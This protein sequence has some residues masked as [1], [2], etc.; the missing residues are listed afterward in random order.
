MYSLYF[1]TNVDYLILSNSWFGYQTLLHAQ[2]DFRE[3]AKKQKL[4][5]DYALVKSRWVVKESATSMLNVL[6]EFK[7]LK[8][9]WISSDMRMYYA[10]SKS[11]V[12]G[13]KI[14]YLGLLYE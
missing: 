14:S 4:V 11:D 6:R 13:S 7:G 3:V 8:E 10:A 9:L 1:N 12:Q 2:Y 5:L